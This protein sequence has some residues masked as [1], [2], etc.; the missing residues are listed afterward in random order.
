VV[1]NNITGALYHSIV[2]DFATETGSSVSASISHSL[3]VSVSEFYSQTVMEA[4]PLSHVSYAYRK[5]ART[6]LQSGPVRRPRPLEADALRRWGMK[7]GEII[8]ELE[9]GVVRDGSSI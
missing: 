1:A 4:A 6:L 7:W 5:L 9:T 3:M 8:A 2:S